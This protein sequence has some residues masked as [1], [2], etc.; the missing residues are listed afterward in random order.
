MNVVLL[1]STI[2]EVEVEQSSKSGQG[3]GSERVVLKHGA[4]SL[5]TVRSVRSTGRGITE[6]DGAGAAATVAATSSHSTDLVVNSVV[7]QDLP[8]FGTIPVEKG[9]D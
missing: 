1:M 5:T 3:K 7:G 4:K 8:I 9:P 6:A 2:E